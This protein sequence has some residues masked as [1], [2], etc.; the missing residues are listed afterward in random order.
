MELDGKICYIPASFLAP[1]KG[2]TFPQ[3]SQISL[4]RGKEFKSRMEW[5]LK[6][7]VREAPQQRSQSVVD[8]LGELSRIQYTSCQQETYFFLDFFIYVLYLSS[9]LIGP[10]AS[11]GS[12]SI[13]SIRCELGQL[14]KIISSVSDCSMK[15]VVSHWA[16]GYKKQFSGRFLTLL[17]EISVTMMCNMIATSHMWLLRT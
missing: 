2:K 6:P 17:G 14:K 15:G 4:F 13:H 12:Y 1:T 9:L 10:C 8:I 11:E 3:S 7:G 16:N 5:T